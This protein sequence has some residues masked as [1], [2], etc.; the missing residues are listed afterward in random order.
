[1]DIVDKGGPDKL[2]AQDR[3]I[4]SSL[5][6]TDSTYKRTASTAVSAAAKQTEASRS[7]AT[8]SEKEG[9]ARLAVSDTLSRYNAAQRDAL[10]LG[11]RVLSQIDKTTGAYSRQ[12]AA[13]K[14]AAD[15]ESRR[16]K[17]SR[18]LSGASGAEASALSGVGGIVGGV[19]TIAK[20]VGLGILGT[21]TGLTIGGLKRGTQIRAGAAGIQGLAGVDPRTATALA[22]IAQAEQVQA[23][24]LGQAFATLG[25]K[26]LGVEKHER[27]VR[28]AVA[29]GKTPPKANAA[30]E[31]FASLKISPQQL[32]SGANNLPALFDL[33]FKQAQKLPAAQQANALKT[34]LGRGATLAGQVEL[35]GPLTKQIGT[36][37][38][39][40]G[41][42]DPEKLAK[43]HETEVRL[44]EATTGL[45]LSF[46]ST[47][48][49]PLISL[50]NK[51]AP[52][53]KP[54]GE[55]LRTAVT[56]PL[57]AAKQILPPVIKGLEEAFKSGPRK[58]PVPLKGAANIAPIL[59]RPGPAPGVEPILA[60]PGRFTVPTQGVPPILGRPR[61]KSQVQREERE[62]DLILPD[63]R[64]SGKPSH[65]AQGAG[66]G[67]LAKGAAARQAAEPSQFQKLGKT[68][69]DV[70]KTIGAGAVK[71][72]GQLL[73]AFKPAQPFFQNVLL[74]LVKGVAIGVLGGLTV[75]IP[76]IKILAT[77]LGAVGKVAAPLK[78]VLELLGKVIGFIF[79]G[80]ILK[81]VAAVLKI[82]S[83]IPKLG[84]VFKLL[85]VPIDLARA[86]FGLFGQ[87]AERIGG[88]LGKLGGV[89]GKV[90]GF[91]E[92][93]PGA[94]GEVAGGVVSAAGKIVTAAGK[95]IGR[96][97]GTLAAVAIRAGS[98]LI[99]G[100]DEIAG[101]VL[102]AFGDLGTKIVEAIVEAIKG[103]PNA[104]VEALTS[105]V[106][107]WAKSAL[108]AIGIELGGGGEVKPKPNKGAQGAP[109]ILKRATGG[110]VD[111][112]VSP[113]EMVMHGGSAWTVPGPRTGA[114]SVYASLPIG[115]AVLT[116]D[117]QRRMSAGASVAEA[118]A[119]QAPHFRTGGFVSTAYG[120]PWGGIEGGGTTATGINLS[121][122][123]H[124]Y[125]VA[126]D[127][128]V[129]PLHS[130]LKI[131]PNPFGYGGAFS[132]EDT[133][134]AIK[135]NRLDFYDW[136]GRSD[137][138]R[139]GVRHVNVS[140]AGSGGPIG[141]AG[142]SENVTQALTL[143][144]SRVRSGLVP[145]A[146]QQ[147]IEA[148]AAGL[149]AEEVAR[150]NRGARG[151][152]G[153]PLNKTISEALGAVSKSVKTT[154]AGA[155]GKLGKGATPRMESMVNFAANA[156]HQ[157]PKY[158]YGGGHNSN[159]AGP[160]DCSGYV[161]AI[162]HSGGLL[163]QPDT[164]DSLKTYGEGGVGKRI[165]VGVRGST[166]KNAHALDVK[167][168]LLTTNGWKT[169][170]T[171]EVGDCVYAEDGTPARV[172]H[173]SEVFE[174]PCFEVEFSDG[175]TLTA[176][177]DHRWKVFDLDAA[178]KG[179]RWR[180]LSTSDLAASYMRGKGSKRAK[181][182]R[183]ASDAIPQTPDA[184]LPIDPYVLGYW[185][186]DGNSHKS[187]ITVG[188]EDHA[189]LLAELQRAGYRVTRDTLTTTEYGSGHQVYFVNGQTRDATLQGRLKLL[190]VFGAAK[191]RVPE[192]YLTASP[193]QRRA[194]LAGL[195]DSDGCCTKQP[196]VQFG[197]RS[198]VLAEGVWLLARSL[199]EKASLWKTQGG[200]WYV[201]WTPNANPFRM[202]RKYD[203]LDEIRARIP[204]KRSEVQ[205]RHCMSVVSVRRVSTVPTRCIAVD[206]PEHVFLAGRSFTPTH[207]TM[208]R[209]GNT[210]W[211]AGG[212]TGTVGE[213]SG[214]DGSFPI[215]RHPP[216]YRSGGIIGTVPKFIRDRV[217]R[218]PR[219][220]TDPGSADF[221]GY[222]LRE[223]GVVGHAAR[224]IGADHGSDG[225]ASPIQS[226]ATKALAGIWAKLGSLGALPPGANMPGIVLVPGGK[227]KGPTTG[228]MAGYTQLGHG[229][230][231]LGSELAYLITNPKD[232]GWQTAA[233][234]RQVNFARQVLIHESAHTLQRLAGHRT[235]EVEGGAQAWADEWAPQ[236]Y[237]AGYRSPGDSNYAG[238]VRQVRKKKGM[239]WVNRGQFGY[240][241]GGVVGTPPVAGKLSAIAG[242]P[243]AF[244]AVLRAYEESLA[245]LT[246]N[247]LNQ[248]VRSFT[249]SARKGGSSA[250]VQSFQALI[251]AV[252]GQIGQRIGE[253]RSAITRRSGAIERGQAS[254]GRYLAFKGVDPASQEGLK[255]QIA[256]DVQAVT[257]RRRS[258]AEASQALSIAKK[259][260]NRKAI[261]EA[262][263]ELTKAQED[264][265][266][267][268][269]KGVE[270]Q[271]SV[272]AKAAEEAK[273]A[274]EK[275]NEELRNKAQEVVDIAGAHT[276]EAQG[277]LSALDIAQRVNRSAELPQGER[278]K[279]TAIQASL[280]PQLEVAKRAAES[281]HSILE[282]TG[283][284]GSELASA[285]AAVQ[286]AGDEIA[287]A[288][289][290]ATEL[291][292]QAAEKAAEELVE[293]T[294]HRT[295]LDQTQGQ[296]KELEERIAGTYEAGGVNRADFIRNTLIPDLQNEIAALVKQQQT[297]E[298]QG[299]PKLAQQ[300]A[301]AI[302]GKQNGVLEDILQANED[303]AANTNPN[304]K[305]GGT[306]GF[307]F[308]SES[309]TDSIISVGSGA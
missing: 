43:L 242:N 159:F 116:D 290:E 24:G 21:A 231:H 195:L 282:Q 214:W 28:T 196:S 5:N 262:R 134:G 295:T 138:N 240:R 162:L 117:G 286:S 125:I 254:V 189:H 120:P 274:A 252:E 23:R 260:G 54:I 276:Q 135:G 251:S 304:H 149:T 228:P 176:S 259:T 288:L 88:V 232:E 244:G 218:N 107:G 99:S 8:A 287:S 93:I 82:A 277:T 123:P 243:T 193:E 25:T 56:V 139:W 269:V 98:A 148:G 91:F 109:P 13:A 104:I 50:M 303:V 306:L 225:G 197:V 237:G 173:T 63:E 26:V 126:V 200:Y 220:L 15:E 133:G 118:I 302:A 101:K 215:K 210:Y 33:V 22:V 213:R 10:A 67:I 145:D 169:M 90:G 192:L 16:S 12:A 46:A 163:G 247:R 238:Y 245:G 155:T 87:V 266:D 115:A 229:P 184:D 44:K 111:A 132:A 188:D 217:R 222:G 256:A 17:V 250:V 298:A 239:G 128:S 2:L 171:V 42:L 78:G 307:A 121:K 95:G 19:G 102:G 284:S 89:A 6:Q 167:T 86:A 85:K 199:G 53:I 223:G 92:K 62:R 146:L 275:R 249:A 77:V 164:T 168:P 1:L 291:I 79:A 119:T 48:G 38:E 140:T 265:Q 142:S 293:S 278:E 130:K 40:L 182:Y 112:M 18:S 150:A 158:V 190:G 186:G 175:S 253:L 211:E 80:A 39:Q 165:T 208:M 71:Y 161:S 160:F 108:G 271:R 201:S 14:R 97:P 178:P 151:A 83:E 73:A 309:L 285:Q 219:A 296:R 227:T 94:V 235:W 300:I 45:E 202:R 267:A 281:L 65:A 47:F 114:D 105:I 248:L 264:L 58:P 81:G 224:A 206:H 183:V 36:V 29:A 166:G 209:I 113:G 137:Q 100:I 27:E 64:L 246:I 177:D 280:V 261:E 187:L 55:A 236:V 170:G 299:N 203:K 106:P 207:N 308:G 221:V 3:A 301:E 216:G 185:L 136:K 153:N 144:S 212:A 20:G 268:V 11:S 30:E 181:R 198:Q 273:E 152:E 103:A 191:K 7:V 292:R 141:A 68:I 96:L 52:A 204:A 305:V 60:K 234:Q 294:Q 35:G 31:A 255:V 4:R 37:K 272:L 172:T 174:K 283:A 297:A 84:V 74:P 258:V 157:F 156:A 230:L 129:I 32:R 72:G 194:L 147:G 127:P 154:T 75:V 143:G 49:P 66:E 131:S 59:G 41:G 233:G 180:V 122:S 241:T 289:A 226:N 70:L 57:E 110:Y 205:G 61:S 51:V 34:F 279:A 69:G 9:N 263:E 270:D 257:A 76:V 124:L 179:G